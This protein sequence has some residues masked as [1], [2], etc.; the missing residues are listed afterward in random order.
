MAATA[1]SDKA[2]ETSNTDSF[3]PLATCSLLASLSKERAS[4]AD[5]FL[6]AGTCVLIAMLLSPKNLAALV[7]LVQPGRW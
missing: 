3:L 2:S 7:Q 5:N 6:L 4:G 1:S